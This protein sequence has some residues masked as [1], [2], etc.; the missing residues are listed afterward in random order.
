MSIEIPIIDAH[1][2]F[3][4]HMKGPLNRLED[5]QNESPKSVLHSVI[6]PGPTPL[7]VRPGDDRLYVPARWIRNSTDGTF[8]Y[9]QQYWDSKS[10]DVLEEHASSINPYMETNNYW[11][12]R[13]EETNN[14]HSNH[15]V[16]HIMPIHHPILDTV[17]EVKR[18][19][20][21]SRTIALKVHGAACAVAPNDIKPEVIDLLKS[22]NKPIIV[23]TDYNVQEPQT[24][25]QYIYRLNDPRKWVEWAKTTGIKTLITH[26]ARLSQEAIS[27]AK[28]CDN[29]VFGYGPD[30]LIMAEQDRLFK[31][32]DNLMLDFFKLILPEQSDQIIFDFD[33]GWNTKTGRDWEKRDWSMPERSIEAVESLGYDRKIVSKILYNNAARFFDIG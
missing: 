12:N 20:Y 28:G 2:H 24:N 8:K 29:I 17:D 25:L 16:I 30:L 14:T 1:G 18:L 15:N 10:L 3:G 11:L 33:F 27:A 4:R 32:T 7:Y 26:A 9:V 31:K 22:A 6:S 21:D 13:A 5:Y 23:H 19:L